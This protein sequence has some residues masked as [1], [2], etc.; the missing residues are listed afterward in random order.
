MLFCKGKKWNFY[1][2]RK[3]KLDYLLVHKLLGKNKGLGKWWSKKEIINICND[4]AVKSTF[5]EQT[6]KFYTSHYRMDVVIDR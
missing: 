2:T 4:L 1:N 5:F 3:R 6:P